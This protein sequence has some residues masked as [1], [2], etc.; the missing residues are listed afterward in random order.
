MHKQFI[1]YSF[2]YFYLVDTKFIQKIN[3]II[4]FKYDD[5]IIMGIFIKIF[6]ET[7]LKLVKSSINLHIFQQII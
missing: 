5:R 6:Y 4:L 1:A 7:S 2:I 3:C